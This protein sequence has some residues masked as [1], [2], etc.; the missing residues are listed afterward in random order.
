[1]SFKPIFRLLDGTEQKFASLLGHLKSQSVPMNAELCLVCGTESESESDRLHNIRKS[2][3]CCAAKDVSLPDNALLCGTSR[4]L[5]ALSLCREFS[6]FRVAALLAFDTPLTAFAVSYLQ[7][8]FRSELFEVLFDE[9]GGFPLALGRGG[10][11]LVP[12]SGDVEW[13][14]LD[15]FGCRV[16]NDGWGRLSCIDD[17]HLHKYSINA[18]VYTSRS[19]ISSFKCA[20]LEDAG[21]LFPGGA[22]VNL[23]ELHRALSA[24]EVFDYRIRRSAMGYR[25]TVACCREIEESYL[26]SRLNREFQTILPGIN[27]EAMAAEQLPEAPRIC[28]DEDA[29]PREVFVWRSDSEK[30]PSIIGEN[31]AQKVLMR[32]SGAGSFAAS[33]DP[34]ALDLV[35]RI[36]EGCDVEADTSHIVVYGI[37]PEISENSVCIA[38]EDAEGKAPVICTTA[39]CSEPERVLQ[40]CPVSAITRSGNSFS[41]DDKLCIQCFSCVCKFPEH[42]KSVINSRSISNAA[43]VC[44]K[45][46]KYAVLNGIF[47]SELETMSGD[48]K[49]DTSGFKSGK[50]VV[51]GLACVTMTENSAALLID[52]QLVAAVEEERLQRVKH[53]GWK[54]PDR[55]ASS[56]ASDPLISLHEPLPVK[57]IQAV[58][59]Q[60]GLRF[61]DVDAVAFNGLPYRF[62]HSYSKNEASSPPQILREGNLFFVPHHLAHAASSFCM[63]GFEQA[64]VLSID[65]RGDRETLALFEADGDS[66]R[67]LADIPYEPDRS[68]GGVYETFTRILGF[69]NFG[70]GSTMALA[71]FG[72]ADY[73]LAEYFSFDDLKDVRL[74]E[75]KCAYDFDAFSREYSGP[76]EEKHKNLA[77]SVQLA[78]EKNVLSLIKKIP[79]EKLLNLCICGGV[80]LNCRMN[81]RI[82]CESGA[83][84]IFVPPG[85]NDAGTAIGAAMLAHRELT[86]RLPRERLSNAFLGPCFSS[87]EIGNWLKSKGIKAQKMDNP[88]AAT[89]ALLAAGKI[90]CWFSGRMEFGPRALG[91]RSILA[92]PRRA[93]LKDRLNSM[94]SRQDWRPFGVSVM[95]EHQEDWFEHS[96]RSPFMLLALT[97]KPEKR[98]MIPVAV[99]A[100]GSS[101][102]QSILREDHP[103][104]YSTIEAFQSLT[105]I[106][107]L[108]NTSFNRGGEPIVCTPAQAFLSF[109]RMGADALVLEDWLVTRGNLR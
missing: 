81:G 22:P 6:G 32:S 93:E 103:L 45:T 53:Y 17:G 23:P 108:V 85:A 8:A 12:L 72:K 49:S 101:R 26:V 106:P 71:A 25:M 73:D 3:L 18:Q 37:Q 57:A 86:G 52:G 34:E 7:K 62:R 100:D 97:V 39:P 109:A 69:G 28:V 84:N 27:I 59:E 107:M 99:H 58:L 36:L 43:D 80:G 77:A 105:G 31:I 15:R 29:G 24:F 48:Y 50:S 67:Q 35:C 20:G 14:A 94:K 40:A 46:K 55:F 51:L 88:A 83:E 47:K 16:P 89:A 13:L 61:E 82:L 76:L 79:S 102:P 65:G 42:F 74:S 4:D 87:D 75:W 91:A 44:C 90:V 5:Y 96:V 38:P 33:G 68:I 66:L 70:Q 60:A 2:L 95:E 64:T 21:L 98:A 41:I 56:L 11:G 9:E 63:S 78:L 19:G 1:M 30:I 92:D 104:Y 54:H 10:C